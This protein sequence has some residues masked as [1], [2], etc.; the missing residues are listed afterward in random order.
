MK[1]GWLDWLAVAI[2]LAGLGLV[3]VE[4]YFPRV[5]TVLRSGMEA[6]LPRPA[7]G[8]EGQRE[9]WRMMVWIACFALAWIVI[10]GAFSAFD[11][12]LGIV[13]NVVLA[14]LTALVLLFIALLGVLARAGVIPLRRVSFG[15]IG[16][17]TALTG[18]ALQV[19]Q[20]LLR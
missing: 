7:G 4:L 2:E 13:A 16:L 12:R 6:V 17:M 5:T 9:A 20:L 19:S 1:L 18:V 15:G 11:A 14:V 10:V 3:A 8:T